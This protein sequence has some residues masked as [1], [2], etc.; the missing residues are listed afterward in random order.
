MDRGQLSPP[1]RPILALAYS[2]G[3]EVDRFLADLGYRFRNAGVAVAGL[4]QHNEFVR[5]RTKCDMN[6]EEL[7]SGRILQ[8]S[9]YRGREA[10]GCR[11]DVA[12]LYEAAALLTAAI[13]TKPTL[14]I[15]NKFGKI[16]A[17]G[18]GL[19]DALARAVD[20]AIPIMV[21]V[22][23]RNIEQWR[24]FAGDLAEECLA[25]SPDVGRWLS[26]HGFDED[27]AALE[28]GETSQIRDAL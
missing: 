9:E 25:G 24:L 18:G 6:V 16:E 28:L 11:L 13:E 14:V 27:C 20:L 3:L 8:I 21:G 2:D 15:L 26:R 22:P 12:A 1:P 17:E 19:R 5:D 23:Y 10:R 4:V 7:A